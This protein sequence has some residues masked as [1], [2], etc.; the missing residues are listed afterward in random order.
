M[1]C[2]LYKGEGSIR[3]QKDAMRK[4][5]DDGA[6]GVT[7]NGEKRRG[8]RKAL[9]CLTIIFTLIHI[10]GACLWILDT[11]TLDTSGNFTWFTATTNSWPVSF[12]PK[13]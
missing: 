7:I 4:G 12:A 2:H 10:T 13:P 8:K 3:R 1:L 5:E 6:D 11:P 9:P